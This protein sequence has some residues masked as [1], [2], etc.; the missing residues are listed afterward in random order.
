MIKEY[1]CAPDN[2]ACY[3]GKQ[4]KPVPV[5]SRCEENCEIEKELLEMFECV[6]GIGRPDP[7][8]V[9]SPVHLKLEVLILP[10]APILTGTAN[11]VTDERER[12]EYELPEIHF[13]VSP[14]ISTLKT[15]FFASS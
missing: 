4:G 11:A 13:F 5:K 6:P 14:L 8:R 3:K 10:E 1:E 9:P 7:L 15:L 12:N 2:P